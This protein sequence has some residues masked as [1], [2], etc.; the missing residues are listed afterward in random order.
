MYV[1][2]MYVKL[3]MYVCMCSSDTHI[4]IHIHIHMHAFSRYKILADFEYDFS[5]LGQF[6]QFH[7][8]KH[9][10]TIANYMYP[11]STYCTFRYH[12]LLSVL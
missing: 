11:F 3:Y 10:L 5:K 7:Y 9:P 4:H 2:T 6:R 1:C 12:Q 8:M